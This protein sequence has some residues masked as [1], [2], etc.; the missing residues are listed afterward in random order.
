MD[1]LSALDAATEEFGRRL[2]L[3]NEKGWTGATPCSDW[4]VRYLAAHVVG[5]NRFAVL[6]LGGMAGPEAIERVLST[7]QLGDDAIEA[8]A[9]TSAAQRAAFHETELEREIDHP[10]GGI[11][12]RQFLEFRVLSR[13]VRRLP[14]RLPKQDFLT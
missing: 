6:I 11:S 9:T 4:D 14:V 12:G 10:L 13:S 2:A 7:P 1:I 5:G 8:R 3:V